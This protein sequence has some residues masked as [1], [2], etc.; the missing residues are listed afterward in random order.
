MNEGN[1]RSM[2]HWLQL[3]HEQLRFTDDADT[4][5]LKRRLWGEKLHVWYGA[6]R[7]LQLKWCK[8]PTGLQ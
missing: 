4:S 8:V 1:C 2:I 7:K 6:H 5:A 3:Q